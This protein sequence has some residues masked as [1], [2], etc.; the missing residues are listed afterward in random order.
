[1]PARVTIER[2]FRGPPDSAN[3]GYACGLV[4]GLIDAPV[5]EVKLRAP[6]PL[7]SELELARLDTGAELRDGETSI[8]TGSPLDAVALEVPAPVSVEDAVRAR[9][10]SSMMDQ[11]PFPGCFVCGPQRDA[12][13]GLRVV[14]GHVAGTDVV[15]APWEPD[16]SVATA[17][18]AIADEIVWAVLDCPSGIAFLNDP[19]Q[20]MC[21]LG[22]LTAELIEP[23]LPGETYV[24]IGW[25]LDRD[26]RKLH[27]ASAIL[28]PQGDVHA[29]A[30]ALWIEL[31]PDQQAAWK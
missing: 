24:A 26:G 15:A 31:K 27:S 18:G 21:V 29:L 13:D 3:G 8:A 7:E 14:C 1:M 20:P 17:E 9:D 12:G 4:A 22:Q 10:G 16:A 30:R 11:H 19:E 23:V 25:V 6:P 2:R 28:G 5:A